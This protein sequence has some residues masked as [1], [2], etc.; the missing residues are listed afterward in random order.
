MEYISK[1]VAEYGQFVLVGNKISGNK[2]IN[3]SKAFVCCLI[4]IHCSI[5]RWMLL[6]GGKKTHADFLRLNRIL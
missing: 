6:S 1:K 3:F 4:L 5:E 2:R